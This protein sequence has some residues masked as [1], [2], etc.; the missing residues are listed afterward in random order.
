MENIP[1]AAAGRLQI[2]RAGEVVA[3]AAKPVLGNR[4]VLLVAVASDPN[5]AVVVVAADGAAHTGVVVTV[6]VVVETVPPKAR[7]LPVQPTVLPTVMPDGS[8]IVPINVELAP[9]V[10]AAAGAH[11]A[12]QA[13]APLV[14]TTLELADV[15]NAPVDLKI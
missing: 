11:N 3:G 13:D 6:S 4:G 12:V 5:A 10:V 7:A 15:F 8:M 2:G 1:S 14:A 9:M